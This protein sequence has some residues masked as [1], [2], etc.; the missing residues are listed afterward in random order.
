[1]YFVQ[2]VLCKESLTRV[3]LN[4][5]GSLLEANCTDVEENEKNIGLGIYVSAIPDNLGLFTGTRA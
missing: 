3:E 1:M 2:Y 4:Q 5:R